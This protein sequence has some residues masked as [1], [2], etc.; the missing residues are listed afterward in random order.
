M[1]NYQQRKDNKI[2]LVGQHPSDSLCLLTREC[3]LDMRHMTHISSKPH[4]I[5]YHPAWKAS[6]IPIS[7]L[8]RT[9]NKYSFSLNRL[10]NGCHGDGNYVYKTVVINWIARHVRVCGGVHINR[11]PITGP[12]P[13][14]LVEYTLIPRSNFLVV[15]VGNFQGRKLCKSEEIWF[16]RR[17][18]SRIAPLCHAKGHHAPNFLEKTAT[19][20]RN[21]RKFSPSKVTCYMVAHV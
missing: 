1:V 12:A 8:S 7:S 4:L 20:T 5:L 18:L 11:S 16:L 15:I 2:R 19:K 6:L 21:S 10:L 17:K 3:V 14:L 9:C 13:S